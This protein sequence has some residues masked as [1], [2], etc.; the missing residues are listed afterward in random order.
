MATEK[1]NH[2]RLKPK[3]LRAGVRFNAANQE[4]ALDADILD[5]SYTGI[6]VKLKEPLASN[7][8][9][10]I[11]ITMTLPESGTS[12]S[13]HGILKH[14]HNESECGLHYVDHIEGSIDDVM[15]ECIELDES[16]VFIKTH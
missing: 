10:H 6:R 8:I 5:I 2:H 12:F 7:I 16:T 4:I 15:F 9:G 3:G 14:L 11:K 1:R 13:V